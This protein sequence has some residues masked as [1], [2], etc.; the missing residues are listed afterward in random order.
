MTNLFEKPVRA[1]GDGQIEGFRLH[2]DAKFKGLKDE[3]TYSV[4]LDERVNRLRLKLEMTP[5]DYATTTDIAVIVKDAD[6]EAIHQAAFDVRTY[7]ATVNTQGKKSLTVVIHAGFAVA[8]DQR[9]TP[10]T[11][12]IDSLFTSSVGVKVTQHGEGNLDFVP[13]IPVPIEFSTSA[14]LKD[15][16]DGQRP[17]GYLRFRERSSNDEV[18]RVP[19]DIGG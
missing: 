5:E 18:L 4:K 8:D 16:P 1:S 19:I 11:V 6:G 9:E 12:Q 15:I 14:E 10:I 13:S 17:V 2:K 7:E 3:L